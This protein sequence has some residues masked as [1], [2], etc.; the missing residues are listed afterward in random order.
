MLRSPA[1]PDSTPLKIRRR[2]L[3]LAAAGLLLPNTGC[4]MLTTFM[5]W[6]RGNPVAEKFPGLKDKSV[7]VVCLDGNV[8]GGEGDMLARRVAYLLN[9]NGKGIKVIEHQK[10]VDWMDKQ[11]ENIADFKEVGRG[12]K[13][14]MVLGIDLDQFSTH[15]G[16]T[17]L[18]GRSRISVKVFDMN[19]NGKLV[20]SVPAAPVVY[21]ENGP[22][23]IGENEEAFKIMFVDIVAR[24]ISK[25]FYPYDKMEDFGNDAIFG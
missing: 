14:D 2:A 23:P 9:L 3:L 15:E 18:R 11:P 7:A 17:L 12:V 25:D 1:K 22:R 8:Q 4:G 5:Y 16:P 21:P 24:K 10:V 6:A 13:A 19:Q 20:Y